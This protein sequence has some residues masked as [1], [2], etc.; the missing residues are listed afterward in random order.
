MR[1]GSESS[2]TVNDQ[3][4]FPLIHASVTVVPAYSV[5]HLLV[6]FICFTLHYL[7]A[8]EREESQMW[9]S[10]TASISDV[11]ILEALIMLVGLPSNYV[12]NVG[13]SFS[14]LVTSVPSRVGEGE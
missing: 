14:K 11:K 9:Q 2:T 5:E 13:T 1:Y 10:V 6:L 3:V 4:S 7:L 12:F 8:A